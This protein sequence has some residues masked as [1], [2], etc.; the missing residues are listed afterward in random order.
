MNAHYGLTL[1]LTCS[2]HNPFCLQRPCP[3]TIWICHDFNC[4]INERE[5]LKTNHKGSISQYITSLVINSL[6]KLYWNKSIPYT[7]YFLRDAKFANFAT[8][9]CIM[10]LNLWY[11]SM[12]LYKEP[13]INKIPGIDVKLKMQ[14]ALICKFYI[15]QKLLGWKYLE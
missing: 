11:L 1:L 13:I 15:P 9:T 14:F 2:F 10:N 7:W 3:P 5:N 4:H 8:I 6:T 12:Y